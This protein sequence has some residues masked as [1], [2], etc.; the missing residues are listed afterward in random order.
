MDRKRG[1]SFWGVNLDVDEDTSVIEYAKNEHANVRTRYDKTISELEKV[2]PQKNLYFGL[3]E[4]LMTKKGIAG[5]SDYLE[6]PPN[7]DFANTK[8][9]VSPKSSA[10][11]DKTTA[12]VAHEYRDVY[13]FCADRFPQTKTL[14]TGNDHL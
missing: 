9:N 12:I 1:Q 14:W 8:V 6:L 7:Y 5:I 2:I 3:Y 13:D 4:T 11:A 10:L